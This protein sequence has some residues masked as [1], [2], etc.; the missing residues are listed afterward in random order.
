[1]REGGTGWREGG[2]EERREGGREEVE[3]RRD[4]RSDV[5]REGERVNRQLLFSRSHR[6]HC[7]HHH[8]HHH[9]HPH[10]RYL[11]TVARQLVKK[12]RDSRSR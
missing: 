12:L 2:R 3:G 4:G 1:V 11:E 9:H 10:L 7:H 6:R 8:H 5:A